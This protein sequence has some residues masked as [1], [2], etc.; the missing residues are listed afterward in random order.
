MMNTKAPQG[1]LDKGMIHH[2]TFPDWES[3]TVV[4]TTDTLVLQV[5]GDWLTQDD[6]VDVQGAG[7][8]TVTGQQRRCEIRTPG[9]QWHPTG[10]EQVQHLIVVYRIDIDDAYTQIEGR[11]QQQ[12]ALRVIIEPGDLYWHNTST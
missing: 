8:L 4:T 9:Y 12:Q 11:N 1:L 10:W 2:T 6:T 7:T 3:L 5:T